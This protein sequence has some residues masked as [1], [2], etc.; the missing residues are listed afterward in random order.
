MLYASS[1]L[2]SFL[3]QIVIAEMCEWHRIISRGQEKCRYRV[4]KLKLVST[5]CGNRRNAG[6]P[7]P[8]SYIQK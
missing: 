5:I 1:F 2:M 3:L 8:R 7:L 4:Q 6:F